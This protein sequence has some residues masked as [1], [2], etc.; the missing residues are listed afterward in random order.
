MWSAG[1]WTRATLRE[2]PAAGAGVLKAGNQGWTRPYCGLCHVAVTRFRA[3][4]LD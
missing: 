1:L 3:T 4:V 2:L